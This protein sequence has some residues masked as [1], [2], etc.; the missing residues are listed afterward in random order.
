MDGIHG[1]IVQQQAIVGAGL[2]D[3]KLFAELAGLF[4]VAFA[5]RVD[6]DEAEAAQALEVNAPHE[7]GA[8]NSGIKSV[9]DGL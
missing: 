7:A 4:G 6:V 1:R 8:E 9:H 5:N 2:I 3:V